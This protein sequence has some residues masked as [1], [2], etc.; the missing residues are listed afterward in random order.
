MSCFDNSCYLIDSPRLT[1][2]DYMIP[3][4]LL[5]HCTFHILLKQTCYTVLSMCL[6]FSEMPSCT[7]SGERTF[8]CV[9]L[10]LYKYTFY[11]NN[12]NSLLLNTYKCLVDEY[13]DPFISVTHTAWYSPSKPVA[14]QSFTVCFAAFL[15]QCSSDYTFNYWEAFVW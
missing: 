9:F 2:K 14:L 15:M 12:T 11:Y 3:S 5:K 6:Q 8:M 13:F 10:A 7:V 4:S 1:K